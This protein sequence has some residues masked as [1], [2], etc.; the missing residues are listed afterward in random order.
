MVELQ[1]R[2]EALLRRTNKAQS[3]VLSNVRVNLDGRQ[4]FLND[5]LVDITPQRV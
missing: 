1:A 5:K 4:A 2:V 3:F